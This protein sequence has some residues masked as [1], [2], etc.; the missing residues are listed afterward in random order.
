MKSTA[1]F[2]FLFICSLA[3]L[4]VAQ[5]FT[6]LGAGFLFYCLG[7]YLGEESGLRLAA[8]FVDKELSQV[9]EEKR[10]R[11]AKAAVLQRLK[12]RLGGK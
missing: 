5:T 12:Y 9:P 10:S 11:S 6:A 7:F 2:L 3:F 1:L 4:G 8:M